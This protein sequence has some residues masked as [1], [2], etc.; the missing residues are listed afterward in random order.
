M[1]APGS[2][3]PR[4]SCTHP[5]AG[6]I[7]ATHFCDSKG[8]LMVGYMPHR[9]TIT[10]EYYTNLMR[11]LRDAIK[12]KRRGILMDGV[13]ILHDNTPGHKSRVEFH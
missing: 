12:W 7:L 2:T 1:E 4:K 9:T 8:I 10:G 3:T 13:L 6:K 11:K 5:S